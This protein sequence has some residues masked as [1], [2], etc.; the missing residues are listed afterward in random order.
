MF[1]CVGASEA[2][3]ICSIERMPVTGKEGSSLSI[4]PFA[5]APSLSGSPVVL[6]A[7]FI[8]TNCLASNSTR[9]SC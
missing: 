9:C 8:V 6:M 5:A 7:N 1:S 2:A 4:S 3:T